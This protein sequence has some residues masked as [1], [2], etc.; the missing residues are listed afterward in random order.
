MKIELRPDE[1]NRLY[2]LLEEQ[3]EATGSGDRTGYGQSWDDE[4]DDINALMQ[5]LQRV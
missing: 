1:A 5:K 2:E 4:M 3:R